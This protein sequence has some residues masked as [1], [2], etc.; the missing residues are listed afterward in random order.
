MFIVLI[1]SLYTSRVIINTLGVSD[2]GIYNVVGGVITTLTFLTNALSAGSNRFITYDLGKGD[3]Q[4][5]KRTVSNIMTVHFTLAGIVLLLAETIG[6]WFVSTQ[7][8]I[9]AERMSAAMWVYQFSILSFV[10]ALL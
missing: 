8:V 3:M 5:L 10:I 7:L 2:Y 9:P 4:A 6:L 1:V